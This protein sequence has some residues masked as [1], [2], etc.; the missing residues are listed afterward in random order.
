[1]AYLGTKDFGLEVSRGN[2]N[3]VSSLNKFGRNVDVDTGTEDI[4]DGGGTWVAPTTA[5]LHDIVS[6][7]GSDTSGGVGARTIKVFGMTGWGS[8]ETSE[9]LTLAGTSSI[10]TVNSYVIIHRM[11]V[12]TKGGTNANVGT[13]TAT[14]RTDGTV[15]A[16]INVVATVGEGQTQMAIYGIPS[17]HSLYLTD[18]YVSVNKGSG[19]PS[20]GVD[21]SLVYNPEPDAEL[22][23]F[24]TKH[25][26]G[27]LIDSTTHIQQKFEPPNKFSGPGILKIKATV[28]NDNWDISAG[29]NGYLVQN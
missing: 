17:T 18:Y 10:E 16:Q 12:E 22:V 27:M 25:T 19:A 26:Q 13:I 1:M 7:S 5:R 2:V 21:A 6:T 14:A 9:T 28:A 4:W 24:L 23:N 15:T 8:V 11:S 20:G 3:G 29:F